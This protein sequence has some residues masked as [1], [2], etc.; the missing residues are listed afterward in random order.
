MST[1]QMM[2]SFLLRKSLSD[3]SDVIDRAGPG[4]DRKLSLQAV[5]PST[6][7]RIGLPRECCWTLRFCDTVGMLILREGKE[8]MSCIYDTLQNERS[9]VMANSG[10]VIIRLVN[11]LSDGMFHL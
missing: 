2:V 6:V 10:F 11:I 3:S 8:E 9:C 4:N 1:F 7:A 5:N